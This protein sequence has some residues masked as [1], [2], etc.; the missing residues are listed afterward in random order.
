MAASPEFTQPAYLDK[1]RELSARIEASLPIDPASDTALA[2]VR[3]WFGLLEPFSRAATPTMWAGS[4][5]LYD[6]MG[7]WEGKVDAGF[8]KRVW[9]FMRDAAAAA[10]S[11]GKDVGPLPEWM[12]RPS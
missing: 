10:R 5:R 12:Q 4:M 1:W 3:E 9:D 8:S 7:A 11:A 2:F 6:D